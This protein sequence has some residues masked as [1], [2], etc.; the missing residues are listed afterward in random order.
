MPLNLCPLPHNNSCPKR[1]QM[2]LSASSLS[3]LCLDT[4]CYD[5]LWLPLTAAHL[6]GQSQSFL[7]HDWADFHSEIKLHVWSLSKTLTTKDCCRNI[8]VCVSIYEVWREEW[9]RGSW[10]SDFPSRKL[11][12]TCEAVMPVYDHFAMTNYKGPRNIAVCHLNL[13]TGISP[14]FP[15]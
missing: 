12:I 9:L 1:K 15:V 10:K 6:S 7:I 5:N 8:A 4:G 13:L 3:A 11:T 14:I 2:L